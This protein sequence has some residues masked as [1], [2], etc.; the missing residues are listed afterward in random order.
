ML[1]RARRFHG[2]NALR[3]VYERGQ[4]IRG[5]LLSLRYVRRQ[6]RPGYRVAVVVSRK[7]HKSAVIRNRL[8]RRVYEQVRLNAVDIKP[9]SDL[10]FTVFSDKL[11]ET[12]TAQL[13]DAVQ[14]LI[15][16]TK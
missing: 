10:V 8:R 12:D 5:P 9:G 1:G 11:L 13:A 3:G 16:K 15:L 2:Y 4:T 7:V 14:G 6:G